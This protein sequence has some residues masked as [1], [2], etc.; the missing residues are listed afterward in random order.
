[1][2]IFSEEHHSTKFLKINFTGVANNFPQR[3]RKIAD[4]IFIGDW[5]ESETGS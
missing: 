3:G 2:Q 1:M 5:I 4:M